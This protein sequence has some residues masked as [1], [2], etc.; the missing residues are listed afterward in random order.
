MSLAYK[1]GHLNRK[2]NIEHTRFFERTR[3][4]LL[5]S[6]QRYTSDRYTKALY[7]ISDVNCRFA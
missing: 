5:L 2:N 1:F 6:L 3:L 7:G 4:L